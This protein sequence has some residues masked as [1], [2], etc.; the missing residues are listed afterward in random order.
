MAAGFIGKIDTLG[1][2][3]IPKP[4]RRT[5]GLEPNDE[6]E[7][8]TEENAIVLTK[9]CPTCTFCGEA[10][11]LVKYKGKNVCKNCREELADK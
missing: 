4:V 3:I 10:N 7:I 8:F 6:L 2:I 11:D 9:H 5:Y 1:R